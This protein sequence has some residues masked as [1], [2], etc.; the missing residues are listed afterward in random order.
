MVAFNFAR[1]D[2][3]LWNFS[4][5]GTA[6]GKHDHLEPDHLS[7]ATAGTVSIHKPS[8]SHRKQSHVANNV[9]SSSHNEDKHEKSAIKRQRR[10][11]QQT[12]IKEEEKKVGVCV[13]VFFQNFLVYCVLGNSI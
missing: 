9:A 3:L 12:D 5:P 6:L 1:F 2:I 10:Q 8:I 13:I 4:D 7:I 11:R